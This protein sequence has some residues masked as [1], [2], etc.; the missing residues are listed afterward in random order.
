[1]NI[2]DAFGS[3]Q[4]VGL[5]PWAWVQFESAEA[6]GPFP[7]IGGIAP[8]VVASLHEAHS[9]LLSGIETAISDVFSR[10]ATVDE[11]SVR[12]RLEDAYAELVQSR[13]QLRQH[14]R[15]GRKPD[16]SFFWEY[17]LDPSKSATMTYA[18]LRVFNSM[19]RQMI[20]FGF[21]RPIG[22]AVGKFL[23]FLDG[24]R[25]ASELRTVALASGRDLERHL[26]RLVELLN[27][28]DCLTLSRR[29]TVGAEWLAATEDRDIVHLGHA[30]LLY[31]Q[32]GSFFLFDPWL[33]PWFAESSEPSLWGSLLPR[34]AAIFLTHDHDD[35]VDPRTLLHVPK[36]IPIIVPSRRNRKALYYDYPA[37]M[38]E[39]G[40]TRVI[41]LP[42]G[43][44]WAFDG[45]AVVSVPF[46]GEDPC[47]IEMPRNC[48]LITDR[49]RNTLVHVDSGPTNAG[50]S[51]VKDG[52]IDDLVRR[53]GPIATMFAS[54]QQ[55]LEVRTY[56]AHAPFCHPG[57]WLEVG[58]NGYLTNEY[59]S[60][61]AA[62]AKARLFVSYATGGADWYPDH[63]SF[64][65]SRRNP[66]RT[67]L[68]TGNWEPPQKLK[69]KLAPYGCDYHYGRALDI[70]RASADGGTQIV[71][72]A[73]RLNPLQLYRL[74]H[75]DPPF[76][77][78]ASR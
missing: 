54:Q 34:P 47:D 35:H 4:Y 20:P 45:G 48:Y 43:E 46:F 57:K 22:P 76:M 75:G 64:M 30:A 28:H 66:A 25:T 72:A 37:L 49:G 13:P 50:R 31:R 21:E 9:L 27:K 39:L 69:D 78:T 1:M 16:G 19:A 23:G 71:S 6:P 53:Y 40:F 3:D 61:L 32:R 11:P 52:V 29:A 36:D 41:E 67:A 17:P 56:A 74:D 38:R 44:T 68:L 15:C 26:V 24:T 51:A 58:E 55:L 18:G 12:P 63:L 2:W 8:E 14:I 77:K 62:A 5:A 10:R 33:M 59:L 42:H 73:E 65:F 70:F 60:Q 7:F